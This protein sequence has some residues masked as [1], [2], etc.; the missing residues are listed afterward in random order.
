MRNYLKMLFKSSPESKSQ[1]RPSRGGPL[2]PGVCLSPIGTTPQLQNSE[3]EA[4]ASRLRAHLSAEHE[5]CDRTDET[6]ARL[7]DALDDRLRVE[8]VTQYDPSSQN[9][10][11]VDGKGKQV[12]TGQ[13]AGASQACNGCLDT[14]Q[15]LL[16][17][18]K[19]DQSSNEDLISRIIDLLKA[20]KA[21][22][23]DIKLYSS[24]VELPT[25]ATLR[26]I[27]LKAESGLRK[28][29]SSRKNSESTDKLEGFVQVL[30]EGPDYLIDIALIE[31]IIRYVEV[32]DLSC[33][34][35]IRSELDRAIADH[36]SPQSFGQAA[37]MIVT[38]SSTLNSKVGNE[39]PTEDAL[40]AITTL[41]RQLQR[42]VAPSTFNSRA[43]TPRTPSVV[44]DP[45][46]AS[47]AD[48]R[49][50]ATSHSSSSDPDV[51]IYQNLDAN[52]LE[53][54]FGT[55]HI[56]TVRPKP[57][58]PATPRRASQESDPSGESEPEV[59]EYRGNL[60]TR[61]ALDLVMRQERLAF[62]DSSGQYAGEI[63]WDDLR[64]AWIPAW[65]EKLRPEDLADGEVPNTNPAEFVQKKEDAWANKI[66]WRD[67]QMYYHEE[68][69]FTLRD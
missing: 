43:H 12:E 53:A 4:I 24:D 48:S 69:K 15:R 58:V 52:E 47:P 6:M 44:S 19:G 10:Q 41:T 22:L 65:A 25:L 21:E 66:G 57:N 63:S 33:G 55:G 38:L 16:Q 59:W 7:L 67:G 60:L 26:D 56:P 29:S 30:S 28:L 37:E 2:P 8:Q 17:S 61:S 46:P 42:R 11:E 14:A 64:N 36:G 54:R 35:E 1:T 31:A 32:V 9:R 23:V 3:L 34:V 27:Y 68:P 45:N 20:Q 51:R 5:S 13:L 50:S 39:A 49:Q 62:A 18:R 40:R